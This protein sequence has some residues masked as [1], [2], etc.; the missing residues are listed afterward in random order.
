MKNLDYAFKP[1]RVAIIG[2]SPDSK[3][4]GHQVIKNIIDGGYEGEI[5]PIHPSAPDVLGHKAYKSLNDVPEGV[6]LAVICIP[7]HLVMQC[8][9]EC[10]RR[11]VGA[12]ALITSGFGEVGKMDE[13]LK[14]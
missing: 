2:A 5:I 13:E 1:K 3:K 10:G 14:L 12:V 7:A 8:M 9:E 4:I 11:K 6:D